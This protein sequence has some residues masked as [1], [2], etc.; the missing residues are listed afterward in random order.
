M[1]WQVATGC[2]LLQ[3]WVT[4]LLS[5]SAELLH[6][7]VLVLALLVPGV[8]AIDAKACVRDR[9]VAGCVAGGLRV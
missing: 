7:L 6:L 5:G 4:T 9:V 8:Y 2:G 1:R 3:A